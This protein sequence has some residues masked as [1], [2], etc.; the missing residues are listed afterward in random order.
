MAGLLI[1]CVANPILDPLFIF[2]FHW[3]VEG[4][5][6]ATIIGQLDSAVFYPV[7]FS[8]YYHPAQKELFQTAVEGCPPGS[9]PGNF[10]LYYADFQCYRHDDSK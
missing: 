3:G 10:Q 2:V 1:G 4:A 7:L 5:A 6:W 9:D 8:F